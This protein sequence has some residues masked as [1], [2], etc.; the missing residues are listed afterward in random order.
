MNKKLAEKY[1]TFLGRP[2]TGLKT[3][4]WTTE[5]NIINDLTSLSSSIQIERMSSYYSDVRRNKI[6]Q[7]LPNFIRK[8]YFVEIINYVYEVIQK[9]KKIM[10]IFSEEAHVDLWITKTS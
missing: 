5:K 4:K 10:R 6:S 1:L 2:T 7:L 8:Y 3:L 9:I